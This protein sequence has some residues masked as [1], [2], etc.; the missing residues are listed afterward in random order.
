MVP[1]QLDHAES[2]PAGG[3][4]DV[5]TMTPDEAHHGHLGAAPSPSGGTVFR[6]TLPIPRV[7]EEATGDG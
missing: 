6:L 7:K 4:A 5:T 1:A 3:D 2:P